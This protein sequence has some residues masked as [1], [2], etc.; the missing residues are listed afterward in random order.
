M[1]L[2]VKKAVYCTGLLLFINLALIAQK[3]DAAL[4]KLIKQYPEEKTHIHLDKDVYLSGETI[5]FKAYLYGAGLP[6]L[7]SKNFYIQLIDKEGKL[8]KEGFY[9]VA[10]AAASGNITIP[11]SL[12]RGIYWLRAFTP[13][14]LNFGEEFLYHRP[15]YILNSNQ[16]DAP[17]ATVVATKQTI[18]LQFFPEGGQLVGGVL[19]NVAF[20]ATNSNG[21]PV[22]TEGNIVTGDG[23]VITSFKTYYN[24]MGKVQFKPIEGNSYAGEITVAGQQQKFSLPAVLPAG[25]NLKVMDEKGGKMFQLARTAKNKTDFNKVHLVVIQRKLIVFE[26]DVVF[27]DYPSVRGHILTDNL[28]SGI[29]HFTVFDENDVPI[30]ERLSF[31]NNGEYK[32]N[33]SLNI[34]V[35]SKGKREKNNFEIVL[36]DSVQRSLSVSVADAAFHLPGQETIYSRFLLSDDLNGYILNP[37]WYFTSTSDTVKQALD[38]LMLTHGWRKYNWKKILN[39][40]YPTITY[41][42]PG[43]MKITGAVADPKGKDAIQ[44]GTLT[45]YFDSPGI[46][47][48]MYDVPVDSRGRFIID[49]LYLYGATKISYLYN[50]TKGKPQQVNIMPDESRNTVYTGVADIGTMKNNLFAIAMARPVSNLDK[51]LGQFQVLEEVQLAPTTVKKK[52]SLSTNEKYATRPFTKD[53]RSTFDFIKNPPK[54]QLNQGVIDFIR[55]NIQQVQYTGGGFVSRKNF[56]LQGGAAWPVGL[57]LDN[58]ASTIGNLQGLFMGEIAMIKFYETGFFGTGTTASGGTLAIFMK[59]GDDLSAKESPAASLPSFTVNGYSVTKEF[60]RPDYAVPNLQTVADDKSATLYWNPA[61]T[62]AGNESKIN[63][64]YFNNDLS[65]KIKIVVEGFDAA[66]KLIHLEKFVE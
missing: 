35:V 44:G 27:D 18:S 66:G 42:D 46:P 31:V 25:I 14:M 57:Y 23:T 58:S 59:R 39:N 40:E 15:L 53:A 16:P 28:P 49:S 30:A 60:Y 7:Q 38:L 1:A 9:P 36:G 61:A 2:S 19:N 43:M 65:R 8:V 6:S 5:W 29:L 45:L 22:E 47:Q 32:S 48:R 26:T 4:E 50:N 63:I 11:D 10:D 20:K 33:V 3:V 54:N 64:S 51:L 56:S 17:V 21:M 55:Q 12:P 37:D 52:D 24:G 62:P 13:W 34:G 41:K